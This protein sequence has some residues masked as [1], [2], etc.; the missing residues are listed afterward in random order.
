MPTG[1]SIALPVGY[2]ALIHPRSGLATKH[3]LT[4]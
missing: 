1:V 2:V 4:W 3:G